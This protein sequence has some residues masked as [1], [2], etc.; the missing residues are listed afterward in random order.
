MRTAPESEPL[1]AEPLAHLDEAGRPHLLREQLLQ[2]GEREE[3]G[4]EAHLEVEEHSPR[5]CWMKRRR[6]RP[7]C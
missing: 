2:V 3:N 7:G 6:S 4:F 5:G 1:T